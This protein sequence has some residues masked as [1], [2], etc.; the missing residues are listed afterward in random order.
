MNNKSPVDYSEVPVPFVIVS[1]VI[2]LLFVIAYFLKKP[3]IDR[4]NQLKIEQNDELIKDMVSKGIINI[5]IF[6]DRDIKSKTDFGEIY[7]YKIDS[8]YVNDTEI[9]MDSLYRKE[10]FIKKNCDGNYYFVHSR[11][12]NNPVEYIFFPENNSHLNQAGDRVSRKIV[13]E[14]DSKFLPKCF[15]D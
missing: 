1:V 2:F 11:I 6:L 14:I 12:E 5:K 15:D 7:W 13:N 8:I 4:F 9:D 10:D 3:E